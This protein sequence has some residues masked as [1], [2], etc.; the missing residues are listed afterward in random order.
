MTGTLTCTMMGTKGFLAFSGL[1]MIML[2]QQVRSTTNSD[3]NLNPIIGILS[4]ELSSSMARVLNGSGYTSYIAA[5]YV[6]FFET[7]GARVVPVLINQN[8]TYYRNIVNSLNGLVFPGGSASITQ[9]SGYGRAG[10]IL[11]DLVLEEADNGREVPLFSICLGFEMLMYLAANDTQPLTS[12]KAKSRADPLYMKQGWADS[13]LFRDAPEDVVRTLN[14]TNAT[15]NFH[16]YCVTEERFLY[17]GLDDSYN[18]L[19]TSKDDDGLEYIST[20]EHR[21]LPIYGFQWHP[22]KN[23]FEWAYKSIPHNREAVRAVQYFTNLF[24]DK[25]RLDNH[26][27]SP[28][29]EEASLIY[30][31]QP[32]YIQSLYKS[33][34]Q[35]CY[36]FK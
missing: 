13:Q 30:N 36:F 17:L 3:L 21:Q 5:S 6:K 15:S 24:I 19:S 4:Q 23:L 12:C 25:A 16:K 18:I 29:E 1:I 28:E 14:F 8:E 11:Y 20:V 35:Q 22:E 34:F 33:S 26:T 2:A 27:F 9:K 32:I 7:G 10:R 31:H